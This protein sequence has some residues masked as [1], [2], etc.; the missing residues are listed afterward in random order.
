MV[1]NLKFFE[2][3]YFKLKFVYENTKWFQENLSEE[4]KKTAIADSPPLLEI[5]AYT[6]FFG[7]FFVGPQVC[8]FLKTLT[9]FNINLTVSIKTISKVC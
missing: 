9:Y 6:Y 5:A 2:P 3:A 7:S 8:A 1:D 4:Q